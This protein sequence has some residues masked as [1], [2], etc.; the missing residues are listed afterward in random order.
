MGNANNAM[1]AKMLQ[2]SR[3]MILTLLMPFLFACASQRTAEKSP[4]DPFEVVNRPIFAFNRGLDMVL[5]KPAAV[6]YR[7]I[8]PKVV[9]LGITNFFANIDDIT[10]A[11]NKVLQLEIHDAVR[12]SMRFVMNSTAG[13]L[14]FYD[15][16]SKA[17]LEKQRADFGLTL[18]HWGIKESPYIVIPVFGPSTMRDG[19]GLVGDFLLSPYPYIPD[20][21]GY[22]VFV[23]D[24]LNI[25]A[26]LLDDEY[27]FNYAA[28]DPYTFMRDVYLQRRR[29]Q[30]KNLSEEGNTTDW[31]EGQTWDDWRT[32]P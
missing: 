3:V 8:L 10:V 12:V 5:V 22:A 7:M 32:Q 24:L 18:A 14:G 19:I 29:A 27:Y 11:A 26:N 17:G 23:I 30:I 25:R 21:I 28:Q 9:R 16:A 1:M 4:D 20:D 31:N 13:G 2:C 15:I 6:G